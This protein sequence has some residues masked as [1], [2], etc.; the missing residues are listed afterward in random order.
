VLKKHV[1]ANAMDK[2]TPRKRRIFTRRRM[3]IGSGAFVG[4]ATL[5]VAG[6]IGYGHTQRFYRNDEVT[7]PDHRIRLPEIYPKLVVARGPDPAA[8]VR[9]LIDR[10]GGMKQFV[11]P[12]DVVVIKPNIGWERT[13]VFG[14]NTHPEVVREIAKLCLAQ[15]PERVIVCD[16]PVARD[17]KMSFELSGIERAALAAGAEVVVPENSS[18]KTVTIS[19]RLGVWDILNPFVIATKI[20]NVPV[21][22]H[23]SLSGVTA[24]MK[25]W[26]GI[27]TKLRMLFHSDIHQSIA[28]LA[29]LMKPT[30]T[31]MDA[32]RILMAKGPEGGNLDDVK[33][34]Q[35]V[36]ASVDPVALDAWASG[37]FGLEKGDW[38]KSIHIAE[39]MGLGVADFTK[40]SPV[41]IPPQA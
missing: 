3:L 39:K 6:Y 28:E 26:I 37:L 34:M 2:T 21:A 38:P 32:T 40:L 12:S 18:Y 14:A 35:T 31:I 24:G 36:A 13:P 10:M 30:L 7:I 15:K 16:C 5:G 17:A 9:S 1:M 29:N 25:N 33:Q 19:E 23:H 22:K 20:I 4:T 41:E 11:S 27:T 8:N